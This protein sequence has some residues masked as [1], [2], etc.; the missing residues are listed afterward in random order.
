MF[1]ILEA[2]TVPHSGVYATLEELMNDLNARTQ[3]EGYKVVKARSHRSKP[4]APIMR[5]DLCCERGGRPYK[6][7][8]TKHKTSTKKT[9]C[10]WKAKA[11]DRKTVG[12]WLLTIMCDQHN[13]EPGTPEPPTP[14]QGSEVDETEVRDESPGEC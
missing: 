5:A 3:K 13:H 9:D 11:V 4:G 14:S 10:P 7:A 1:G 12:G 8:A 6:C 2:V